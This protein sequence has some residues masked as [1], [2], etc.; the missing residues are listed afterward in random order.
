M[1]SIADLADEL[2]Q[3]SVDG[4]EKERVLRVAETLLAAVFYKNWDQ[5]SEK[6]KNEMI[7]ARGEELFDNYFAHINVSC[8]EPKEA[9]RQAI[10]QELEIIAMV[11]ATGSGGECC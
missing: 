1:P 6:E 10:D 9:A 3:I 11:E 2:S 7:C 4:H 8:M 5:I